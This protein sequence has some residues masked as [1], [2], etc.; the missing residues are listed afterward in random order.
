MLAQS[1]QKAVQPVVMILSLPT[2]KA[3]GLHLTKPIGKRHRLDERRNK[4]APLP[5]LLG[6]VHHVVAFLRG[7]RPENHDTARCR[8]LLLDLLAPLG[9]RAQ[10][11]VHP[12]APSLG[13]QAV[14]KAIRNLPVL[15]RVADEDVTHRKWIVPS[16]RVSRAF[17]R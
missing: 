15:A 6:F 10:M 3:G 4:D 11:L 12:H 1:D 17:P 13:A 8:E 7:S 2:D 5:G 16:G 9:S 14:E